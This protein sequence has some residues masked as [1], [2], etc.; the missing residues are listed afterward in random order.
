V[1]LLNNSLHSSPRHISFLNKIKE[2]NEYDAK[3]ENSDFVTEKITSQMESGKS[4]SSHQKSE[5]RRL[6]TSPSKDLKTKKIEKRLKTKPIN[7]KELYDK[8]IEH[9]K[10][11]EDM[12][13]KLLGTLYT[14]YLEE[15]RTSDFDSKTLSN[16]SGD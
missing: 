6:E 16:L 8:F 10:E 3:D 15:R 1:N 11:Q 2:A 13:I 5:M 7:I 12:I 14:D 9:S 4:F